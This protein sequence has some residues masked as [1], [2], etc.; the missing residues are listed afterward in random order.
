M[1]S[2]VVLVAGG[3]AAWEAGALDALAARPGVVVLK[4]CVDVDDLLATAA[5]GQAE[6]ALVGLEAHGLDAT[7]VD[8][9]RRH[10]VRPVGVV[11]AGTTGEQA[12]LR[13]SR[14]GVRTLVPESDIASV[15]E[16]VLNKLYKH[17]PLQS[18]FGT[19]LLTIVDG[20]PRILPLLDLLRYYLD[21]RRVVV[22][23]R[24]EY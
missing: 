9:L 4:R 7:A 1:S 15:G 8:L 24:T 23:R 14:V 12:R 6:V 2:T 19:I 17:T 13:A 21:H 3:G 16:V 22:S 20:R 5:S 11:G 18:T 10:G